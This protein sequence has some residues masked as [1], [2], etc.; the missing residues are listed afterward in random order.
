MVGKWIP[1]CA[2]MTTSV[3]CNDRGK[4]QAS[5]KTGRTSKLRCNMIAAAFDLGRRLRHA[6][7]GC[8]NQGA[9]W[10]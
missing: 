9:A 2:G 3:A 1:A 5:A 7:P 6:P 10:P 8:M 4:P